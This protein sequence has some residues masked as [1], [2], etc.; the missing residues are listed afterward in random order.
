MDKD[1]IEGRF[2]LHDE[3][4]DHHEDRLDHHGERIDDLEG[5]KAHKQSRRLEWIVISLVGLEAIFEVLM[6][7]H[8]HA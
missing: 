7:F 2:E 1:T 3:R 6:Y 4:L 5:E 8:P